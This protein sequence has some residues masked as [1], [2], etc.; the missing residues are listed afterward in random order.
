MSIHEG[1]FCSPL[2]KFEDER[3]QTK[4]SG[5]WGCPFLAGRHWK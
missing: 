4:I 2:L 5:L 1:L 3:Q